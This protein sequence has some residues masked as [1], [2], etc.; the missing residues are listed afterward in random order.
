MKFL[1]VRHGQPEWFR[2]NKAVDDPGLTVTGRAQAQRLARRL[3]LE[4]VDELLVSPL[5]RARETAQPLAEAIGVEPVICDWLAEIASPPWQGSPFEQIQKIFR[6]HRVKPVDQ[7]WDGLEG[8]EPYRDFHRRIT[9]GLQGFLDSR[10]D[11]RVRDDPALWSLSEPGRKVVVV[12]HAGT[13]ATAVGYLLGIP[14]VPWEWERFVSAHAA[15]SILK[16]IEVAD[17]HAYSLTLM[18]DVAHLPPGLI[19]R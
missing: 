1:F 11:Q 18:A 14:P 5:P 8:G 16:P 6:E 3:S 4:H 7:H 15:V 2:D 13:N 10:G 19:T 9:H 17:H 12:A